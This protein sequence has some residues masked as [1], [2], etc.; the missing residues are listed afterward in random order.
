LKIPNAASLILTHELEGEVKG[1][2]DFAEHPPVAPVFWSF[3]VM[4]GVGTLMLLGVLVGRLAAV[5][6]RQ[7]AE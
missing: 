1:L 7:I 5:P 4:T 3:R 6:P 2:N